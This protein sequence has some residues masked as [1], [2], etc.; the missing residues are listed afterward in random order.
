MTVY[1]ITGLSGVGKTTVADSLV[2]VLRQQ[3]KATVLL[4]GDAVRA[5]IADANIGYDIDSRLTNARRIS[6]LAAMFAEQ[7]LQVVVATIS[8]FHEIHAWNRQHLPRYLEIWLTAEEHRLPQKQCSEAQDQAGPIVGI[9]IVPEFPLEYH[10]SIENSG[11]PE[12]LSA[13]VECILQT[14]SLHDSHAN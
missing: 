12:D 4:D 10:L 1:W 14:A 2:Q 9:D 5:A 8:L 11:D 7:N 6:R 13:I 3:G